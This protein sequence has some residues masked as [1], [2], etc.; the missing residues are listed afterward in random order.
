MIT[1]EEWIV[2]ENKNKYEEEKNKQKNLNPL[3]NAENEMK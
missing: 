3:K 1:S 2:R